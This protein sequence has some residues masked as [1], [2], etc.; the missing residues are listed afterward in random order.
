MFLR[1]L[2][3][4]VIQCTI[5]LKVTVFG[6]L[7]Y[8]LQHL[9]L[10]QFYLNLEFKIV[11]KFF[12]LEIVRDDNGKR[13]CAWQDHAASHPARDRIELEDRVCPGNGGRSRAAAEPQISISDRQTSPFA[14]QSRQGQALGPGVGVNVVDLGAVVRSISWSRQRSEAAQAAGHQDGFVAT[15]DRVFDQ[16]AHVT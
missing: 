12:C 3:L 2:I 7:L 6:Q 10:I 14:P 11:G 1:Y 15:A 5:F 4:L 9:T 16:P 8:Q 13:R